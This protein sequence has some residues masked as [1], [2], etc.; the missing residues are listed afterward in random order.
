MVK[1]CIFSVLSKHKTARFR[2]AYCSLCFL[3]RSG[4]IVLQ[5]LMSSVWKQLTYSWEKNWQHFYWDTPF[6]KI[7]QSDSSF[8]PFFFSLFILITVSFYTIKKKNTQTI[9]FNYYCTFCFFFFT[10]PMRVANIWKR[11]A[12]AIGEVSEDRFLSMH[13][14]A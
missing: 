3:R 6:I 13:K 9:F 10:E 11:T 2:A 4:L 8:R 14:G 5:L 12:S 7:H 1:E